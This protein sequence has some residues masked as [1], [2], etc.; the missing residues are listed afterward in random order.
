MPSIYCLSEDYCHLRILE[1]DET[2][3]EKRMDGNHVGSSRHNILY[4][5]YC[6][7]EFHAE[8]NG[9]PE[10]NEAFTQYFPQH[11]QR[12]FTISNFVYYE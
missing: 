12:V 8:E 2:A 6:F 3:F 1:L 4:E 7:N 10:V 9:K 11:F 5:F